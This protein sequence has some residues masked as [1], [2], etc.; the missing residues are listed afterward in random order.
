MH[1]FGTRSKTSYLNKLVP[2]RADNNW[3]LRVWAESY[4]RDPIGVSLFGDSEL[5]VTKSVPELDGAVAR[6]RNDLSVVGGEGDG[7]NIIG[8][9]NKSAGGGTGGKLPEAESLVPRGRESIGTVRGDN[10][11]SVS[12]SDLS[13]Q[14]PV[15]RL[16]C[17]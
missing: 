14:A 2:S 8:V 11:D 6:S 17:H 4:A 7:E 5:A 15:Q 10:L 13:K 9:S 3:V 16:I 12:A 1:K